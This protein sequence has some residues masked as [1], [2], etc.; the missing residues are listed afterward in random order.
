MTATTNSH[1]RALAN[2]DPR[3]L[4]SIMRRGTPALPLLA[5]ALHRHLRELPSAINGLSLT[6]ELALR[7]MSEE[8]HSLSKIYWRTLWETDP[9]PGQADGDVRDRI[10]DMEATRVFTRSP[11][12]DGE[13]KGRA[14]WTDVFAITDL[15]RAVLRGEVDF[16]SLNPPPRWVGGAEIASG[17]ID[18]RWDEQLQDAIESQP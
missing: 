16:R 10:L 7:L 13:G 3:A 1:W 6:E 18:W 11:G 8:P 12:L 17:N 2:P 14:P 5:R 4:A 15:G 9:L